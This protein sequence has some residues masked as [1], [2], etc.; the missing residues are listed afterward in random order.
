M[1]QKIA[2]LLCSQPAGLRLGSPEFM[3]DFTGPPVDTEAEVTT[4]ITA[5]KKT[6]LCAQM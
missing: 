4:T 1:F 3:A 2:I 5:N 6:I